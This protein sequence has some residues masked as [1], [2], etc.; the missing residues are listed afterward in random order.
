MADGL[1]ETSYGWVRVGC[2]VMG[3]G[4]GGGRGVMSVHDMLCVL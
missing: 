1:P 2:L 4:A 3:W